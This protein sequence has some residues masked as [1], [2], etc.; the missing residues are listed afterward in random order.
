MGIDNKKALVYLHIAVFLWGFTAIL[1]KLISYGSFNLVWHR[2]LL[3]ACIYFCLPLVWKNV[4]ALTKKQFAIYCGIGLLVC[5]H[6]IAFYGSIKLGNSA[7]VTLACLGSVS[8]FSAI[9]DPIINKRP[10]K[11]HEIIL[12]LAVLFGLIL[13]YEA[14]PMEQE[15][16]KSYSLAIYT[17]VLSAMLAAL[18]TALNKRNIHHA[19]AL[20]LSAVEMLSGAVALSA[21]VVLIPEW[22]PV[23]IPEFSFKTENFDFLWIL[24]LVVLCTNVTF[25][26]GTKSLQKLTA[27]TANL[28]VNL[29]PIYGIILGVVIF[30]ENESLNFWFYLGAGIVLLSVFIQPFFENYFTTQHQKSVKSK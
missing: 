18:F 17:G 1:G 25:Y 22:F 28:T 13:I 30:N 29:E 23:I 3:S 20:T 11:W 12:G 5:A 8:F 14:R 26:L 15:G 7:S 21:L 27:F 10:F 4:F 2:M 19:S 16:L 9:F 24:I 6:W